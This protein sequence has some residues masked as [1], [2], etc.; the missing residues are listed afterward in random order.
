M[1]P[2]QAR[3]SMSAGVLMGETGTISGNTHQKARCLNGALE[4]RACIPLPPWGSEQERGQP[5]PG[6]PAAPSAPPLSRGNGP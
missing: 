6:E 4:S 2:L 3:V 1:W 5:Q